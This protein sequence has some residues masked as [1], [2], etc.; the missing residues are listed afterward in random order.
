MLPS[1]PTP[2]L[3]TY[4]AYKI[5]IADT[6]PTLEVRLWSRGGHEYLLC[7]WGVLLLSSSLLVVQKC[8]AWCNRAR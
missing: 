4:T 8:I 7:T 2:S 5:I 3:H 6:L 1:L